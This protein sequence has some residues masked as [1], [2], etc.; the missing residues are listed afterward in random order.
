MFPPLIIVL[1]LHLLAA[2][3]TDAGTIGFIPRMF[4][5]EMMEYFF[6]LSRLNS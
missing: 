6:L 5:C 1:W 2:I 3:S 4:I